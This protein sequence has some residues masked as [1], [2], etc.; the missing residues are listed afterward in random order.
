MQKFR[1]T[2]KAFALLAVLAT[3]ACAQS[4][5]DL[6]APSDLALMKSDRDIVPSDPLSVEVMLARVRGDFMPPAA[7]TAGTTHGMS[8]TN[9]VAGAGSDLT[10]DITLEELRR[11]V[12]SREV[13]TADT[14]CK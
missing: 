11:Q 8:G 3:G 5:F 2:A 10:E 1:N 12:A 13:D 7:E 14:G 9:F 4:P 6:I